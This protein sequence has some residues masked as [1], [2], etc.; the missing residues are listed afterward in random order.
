MRSKLTS[1]LL[2]TALAVSLGLLGK[3]G[4]DRHNLG[5]LNDQLNVQLMQA[6]LEKGRALTEFGNAEKYIGELEQEIQDEI[7]ER[8]GQL[9][10]YAQLEAKY[11]TSQ[12]NLKLKTKVTRAEITIVMPDEGPSFDPGKYYFATSKKT[13]EMIYSFDGNYSDERL[14]I[15]TLLNLTEPE[16]K[17]SFDYG[18]KTKLQLTFVE[19]HLPSGAI[20][21]YAELWETNKA[22]KKLR[23][24]P[25]EKFRVIVNKP[26]EKQW[27]WWT[28]HIDVGIIAGGKL[29]P[30]NPLF[31]ASIG[32]SPFGY[33]RTVNDLDW[34]VLRVSLDFIDSLPAVGITPVA[35]NIGQF[36]PL[37]SNVWV[38]PHVSYLPPKGW[39]VGIFLGAML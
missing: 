30:P 4:C 37:F 10:L 14:W 12:K 17:W 8:D 2:I 1:I 18:F 16:L 28:P 32:F 11:E 27:F 26:T 39:G 25:L 15:H 29:V 38:G 19:S 7:S 3:A 34:R 23:N 6:D 20:N 33:G 21:H 5:N 13:L 24:I 9:R 22:G 36:F 35:Y 31:G